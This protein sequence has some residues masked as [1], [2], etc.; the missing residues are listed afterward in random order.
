MCCVLDARST[1]L[2]HTTKPNSRKEKR[3]ARLYFF[4]NADNVMVVTS[5][6]ASDTTTCQCAGH[7]SGMK[8]KV[9]KVL[10]RD[11]VVAAESTLRENVWVPRAHVLSR[12]TWGIRVQDDPVCIE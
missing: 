9:G 6:N 7:T 3:G 8:K 5:G 12:S 10:L 4:P 1:S 2:L 11:A